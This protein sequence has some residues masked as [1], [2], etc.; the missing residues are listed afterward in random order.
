M[1]V[2]LPDQWSLVGASLGSLMDNVVPIFDL[3][4]SNGFLPNPELIVLER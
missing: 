1:S 3:L 2:L 4:L